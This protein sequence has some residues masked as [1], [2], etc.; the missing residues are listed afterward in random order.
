MTVLLLTTGSRGDVQ[1]YVALGRGLEAAGLNARVAAPASFGAFVEEQGLDFAPLDDTLIQL[2]QTAEGQAA[3]DRAGSWWG[4]LRNFTHLLRQLRPAQRR[5]L[6]DAWAAAD[7]VDAVVYHPKA[8]AGPHLA[9]RLGI[10]EFIGLL[11][12]LLVPTGAFPSP[13]LPLLSLPGGR[14]QRAYNR[15]SYWAVRLMQASQQPIVNAWRTETLGLPAAGWLESPLQTIDGQAVP[16]LHAF[17]PSVVPP[18]SDWPPTAHVTGYWSLDAAGDWTPPDALVDFLEAGPPPIYVGFGSMSS[19]APA[20]TARRVVDALR[21]TGQR[22]VLATGWGGLDASA[23][24]ALPDTV[25]VLDQAPHG[26][27]F[28]QMRAVVHHGGAGTTASGLR[29]GR[30]TLVCPF[31]G[32]QPFWGRRVAALGVGPDPIPQD[33]LTTDRLARALR[34]LVRDDAMRERAAALGHTLHQEDGVAA[35]VARIERALSPRAQATAG[36]GPRSGVQA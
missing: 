19:R 32:D 29:A 31:F 4:L 2:T 9:E 8:L 30:P 27:L 10:P 1:P 24:D 33:A 14:L 13:A 6:E 26:W 35:A 7:D 28:P 25:Y 5:M 21:Q 3:L 20:E 22:G 34:R 17:S 12:P 15:L 16:V 18:P 36:A 23:Q 11:Q